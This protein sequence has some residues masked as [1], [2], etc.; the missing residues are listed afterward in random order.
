[1][2][3][4]VAK[5]A[6]FVGAIASHQAV[7]R[8]FIGSLMP[9]IDGADDVLQ[10]VNLVLWEK[11]ATYQEGTNF[12]A[13]ACAIARFKVLN[14]RRKMAKLGV[15]MFDEALAEQLASDCEVTSDEMDAR[16]EAL[17]DCLRRL[18]DQDRQLVEHRYFS[19][20]KLEQF[21]Q[22]CGKSVG[23]LRVALFRTRDALR[24]CIEEKM[25]LNNLQP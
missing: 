16:L 1:M 13:W 20:S 19:G 2:K 3:S 9:G 18:N 14:H 17:S 22:E 4:D 7:L 11:R 23:S 24:K 21:A 25:V 10:E 6:E 12:K 15:R 8:A 5:Q